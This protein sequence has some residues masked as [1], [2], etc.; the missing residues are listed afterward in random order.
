M[1]L[2]LQLRVAHARLDTEDVSIKMFSK[3]MSRW[4]TPAEYYFMC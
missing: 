3:L 1:L 2:T 4:Q